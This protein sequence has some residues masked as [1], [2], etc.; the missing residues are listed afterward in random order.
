MGDLMQ[1]KSWC[2]RQ[3]WS[4]ASVYKMIKHTTVVN[5]HS[6]Q[7]SDAMEQQQQQTLNISKS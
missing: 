6:W 2:A 5:T 1:D 4:M 7:N 3:T